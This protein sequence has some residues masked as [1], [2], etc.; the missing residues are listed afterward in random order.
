MRFPIVSRFVK[1]LALALVT[2]TMSRLVFLFNG[3]EIF[4]ESGFEDLMIALLHGVRF[5]AV[6]IAWSFIPIWLLLLIP[7]KFSNLLDWLFLGILNLATF[8]NIIDTELFKFTAKRMT[9]D[10]FR[11]IFLSDD[12][13][14]I[15]PDL[16]MSFWYLVVAW[17]LIAWFTYWMVKRI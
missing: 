5:D 15:G 6:V 4:S 10:I 3:W 1:I 9:G 7:N 14:H 11:F 8:A 17:C 2:M 13:L 16:L 12:A